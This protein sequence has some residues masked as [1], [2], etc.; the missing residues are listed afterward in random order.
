MAYSGSIMST[1]HFVVADDGGEP[2][3]EPESVVDDDEVIR[4]AGCVVYRDTDNGRQVLVVHRPRYDD[5]DLPKGKLDP[6]ESAV[7]CAV[8]ETREESGYEGEILGELAPDRYR[9]RGRDKLVR[10][11]L[12]RSTGGSFEPNDEVDRIR[13]LSP[14]EARE[15]L[16]Y[17]HARSLVDAVEVGHDEE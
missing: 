10:W 13:W 7:D 1:D 9:V 16:S 12:M 17:G 5:W 8:R 15:I 3:V 6:G 2:V 11:F 4:A 14:H